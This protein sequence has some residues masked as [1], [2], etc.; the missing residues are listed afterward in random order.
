MSGHFT[1]RGRTAFALGL[2]CATSLVL[3]GCQR[4]VGSVSGK[5]T[6][7]G[8]VLKGGG[9]SFVSTDGGQ[10]FAAGIAEDGTYKVPDLRGG[11]YK[12][13][14]ETSSLKAASSGSPYAGV[15]GPKKS[16]TEKAGPPPGA[17]VPEGYTPS[18]PAAAAAV[19]SA[20]RYVAIPEKYSSPDTTDLTYE[21]K[22]GAETF[23]ID[24]K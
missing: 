1:M 16:K 22:G 10:S 5:I 20:K 3:V 7:Q 4:P 24:L 19:T 17:N 23:D 6:Y 15:G 21:F 13:C 2:F 9:V 8:K 11:A 14:V 18:D 12:V